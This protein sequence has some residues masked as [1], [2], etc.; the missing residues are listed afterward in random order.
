MSLLRTVG[1]RLGLALLAVVAIVLGLV[2]LIVVPSLKSR[3]IDS[4]LNQLEASAPRLARRIELT[5]RVRM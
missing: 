3:L 4:K 5:F 1:A 2:Y